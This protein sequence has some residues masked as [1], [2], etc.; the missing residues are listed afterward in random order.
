MRPR[1]LFNHI[2]RAGLSATFRVLP[3]PIYELPSG[4]G[5]GSSGAFMRPPLNTVKRRT[6]QPFT[7]SAKSSMGKQVRKWELCV[8]IVIRMYI[9]DKYHASWPQ[10]L[11]RCRSAPAFGFGK[12]SRERRS[13]HQYLMTDAVAAHRQFG[14]TQRAHRERNAGAA[15]QHV[16]RRGVKDR[17]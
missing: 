3:G 13:K 2:A 17:A 1:H 12:S 5:K 6:K 8:G 11:S 15:R 9:G 10:S 4:F 7:S 14:A 16:R